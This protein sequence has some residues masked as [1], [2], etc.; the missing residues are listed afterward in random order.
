MRVPRWIRLTIEDNGQ[1]ITEAVR[2][3]MFDPFFT[4]KPRDK[5]TGMGLSVSHGIIKDHG[6]E[7]SMESE[8]GKWTR[9]MMDLPIVQC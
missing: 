1:G 8:T 9:F 2:Q 6:G 7:L 3:H 5:G 4:T